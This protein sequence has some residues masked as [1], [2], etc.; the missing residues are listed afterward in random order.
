MTFLRA[1]LLL[2]LTSFAAISAASAAPCNTTEELRLTAS[3]LARVRKDFAHNARYTIELKTTPIRNQCQFGDCWIFGTVAQLEQKYLAKTGKITNL[4]EMHL[5]SMSL[6]EKA[7]DALETRFGQLEQGGEYSGAKFLIKKHGLIPESVWKPRIP[8]D[9]PPHVNRLMTFLD[10]RIAR[11]HQDFALAASKTARAKLLSAARKDVL[12][13]LEDYT[14]PIPETFKFEGKTYTPKQ[15]AKRY[16]NQSDYQPTIEISPKRSETLPPK[17]RRIANKAGPGLYANADP[18]MSGASMQIPMD[19]LENMI[20]EELRQGRSVPLA[21]EVNDAF[22]DN[23]RG[24]MSLSA[25]H[26]PEGFKPPPRIYRNTFGLAGGGHEVA[27][28]GVDLDKDGRVI[29]FKIKNSWGK[30]YGDLGFYHMYRDY[31][32]AYVMSAGVG[33]ESLSANALLKP[34]ADLIQGK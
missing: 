5:N 24:I 29:K 17:L 22:L 9:Q 32:E 19:A 1:A 14:G 8:F 10:S 18:W 23:R 20:V 26:V 27:I 3:E 13:I 21:F 34:V 2:V 11:Y 25:F 33:P 16:L 7:L 28:V 15:F 31:F 30:K 4:S 12:K 6:R